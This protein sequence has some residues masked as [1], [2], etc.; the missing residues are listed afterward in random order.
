MPNVKTGR[1]RIFGE[2]EVTISAEVTE[3]MKEI[4]NKKCEKQEQ[5]RK[6]RK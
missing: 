2:V 1:K 3:R 6:R 5:P 4:V